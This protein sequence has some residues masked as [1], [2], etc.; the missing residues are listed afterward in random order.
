MQRSADNVVILRAGKV[1]A[2]GPVDDL[3]RGARQRVEVW[4]D[5]AP[6][7][8][9]LA[10]VPGVDDVTVDGT[11]LSATVGGPIQ[12]LIDELAPHRVSSL[13]IAEPD[14]EEVFLDLYGDAG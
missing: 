13:V 14:L 10:A 2:S 11:R 12:P 3:R 5:E 4:F 8:A 6:L 9:T 7:S 1:I